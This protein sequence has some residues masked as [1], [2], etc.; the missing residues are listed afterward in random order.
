MPCWDSPLGI[1][2]QMIDLQ[3]SFHRCYKCRA[4][5]RR[6]FPVLAEVRLKFVFFRT[7]CTVMCDTDGANL[8]STALSARSL[9][10]HRRCP[11]GVSEQAKAIS[12]ASNAPSKITSLGGFSRGLRS[13]AASSPSSTKRFLRCSI[14]RLV[15]PSAS[16][17]SATLHAGPWGPASQSNN[18]RAWTNLLAW[19]FPR[20]VNVSSSLRSCSVSVTRY[21]GDMAASWVS[22]HHYTPWS[23]NTKD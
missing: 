4:P 5:F 2:G 16:A 20:R 21:L 13:R 7:R 8:S 3:N 10:V 19:V 23:L 1:I 14:V 15:T 9:T 11:S 6:D 17:T 18:A 22:R 12:L